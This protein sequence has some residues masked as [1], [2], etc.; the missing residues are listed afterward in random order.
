MQ[1]VNKQLGKLVNHLG[2]SSGEMFSQYN[3]KYLQ[4]IIRK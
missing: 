2:F 1:L 4:E 3:N